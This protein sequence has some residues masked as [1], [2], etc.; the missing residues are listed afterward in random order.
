MSEFELK[1]MDLEDEGLKEVMGSS[2]IDATAP[3]VRNA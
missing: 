1:E 2:F 3:P